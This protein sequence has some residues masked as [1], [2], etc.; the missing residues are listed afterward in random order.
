MKNISTQLRLLLSTLVVTIGCV[1]PVAAGGSIYS[2]FGVG[3]LIRYGG[4]RLDAM[5]GAGIALIGD[6]F[7]NRLNPA[8]IAKIQYTRFSG[9]FEYTNYS[10]TDAFGEGRYARGSFKG[11]GLGIPI[12]RE[13]GIAM[14]FEA[15][16][17]SNVNY[18]T[19]SKDSLLTQDFYGTGGLS[20]LSFG[21]SVSPFKELSLGAKLNYIHGRIRQA[22]NFTFSDPTFTNSEIQ[23]SDF[24]SGF[25]FTFGGIYEGLG[26]LLNVPALSPLAIGFVLSTP[27]TLDVNRESVLTTS[28]S[29]DT[30]AAGLGNVDVPLSFGVGLSYLIGNKYYVTGDVYYQPWSK[31]T[32]FGSTLP[33][34]R[35]TTRIGI[36]FEALPGRETEAF[37]KRVIYRAGFYYNA[38]SYIFNGTPIN[39]VF[40]TGG[41]GIPIG[42]DARLNVGLQLGTRGT[43]SNNLQRDT[44][45]RLSLSLSA[46]E[47]WFLRIE[48][49]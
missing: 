21:G 48:E 19:Q 46:S 38:T 2:R 30:T 28:E 32:F 37:L 45:F 20:L 31:A 14:L 23:R 11:L 40:V 4:S 44:V 6:G 43:T 5:G 18:A 7:L 3:D 8:G 24:Y 13:Y 34:M 47:V 12:D 35:N 22:G 39:E 33:Q 25:N 36:G 10:S 29:T 27:T 15:S 1:L 16:P 41:V 42:P 49:E 9:S 26:N 17:Y